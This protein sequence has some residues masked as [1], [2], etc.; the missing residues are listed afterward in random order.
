MYLLVFYGFLA[1]FYPA[2]L[3]TKGLSIATAFCARKYKNNGSAREP[4]SL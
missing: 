2:L 4:F 1:I 3:L